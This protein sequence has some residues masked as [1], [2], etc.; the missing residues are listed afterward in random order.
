MQFKWNKDSCEIIFSK[1]ERKL[2]NDKGLVTV[3]YK[4]GRT[5]VNQ[6]ARI[7]TEIHINYKENN[8]DFEKESTFD[9]SQVR[10]K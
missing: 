3:D 2:I 8:P 9:D 6:L 7:V 1:E 5:F 4:D 10:L